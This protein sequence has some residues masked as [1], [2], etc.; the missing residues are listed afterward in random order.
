VKSKSLKFF[1]SSPPPWETPPLELV[2]APRR[3]RETEPDLFLFSLKGDCGSSCGF[4]EEMRQ[5][6]PLEL[7]SFFPGDR[8]FPPRNVIS[9]YPFSPPPFLPVRGINTVPGN[10]RRRRS[11]T[12]SPLQEERSFSIAGAPAKENF[13]SR[14]WS[15]SGVK[16]TPSRL[17]PREIDHLLTSRNA[18]ST[19]QF[20]CPTR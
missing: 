14:S 13:F 6:T 1:P 19:F 17:L 15:T 16:N 9:K 20:P 11:S 10:Y 4:T 12:I 18:G 8:A 2:R 5:K 7:S 3:R